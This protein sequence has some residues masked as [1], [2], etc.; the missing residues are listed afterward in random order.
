[1]GGSALSRIYFFAAVVGVFFALIGF[2]WAFQSSIEQD[3]HIAQNK[4]N[5]GELLPKGPS[6][7]IEKIAENKIRIY[8]ENLPNTSRKLEVF[9]SLLQKRGWEKW[10]T[11]ELPLNASM[12]GSLDLDL[13]DNTNSDNY[14][15]YVQTLNDAGSVAWTGPVVKAFAPPQDIF[16]SAFAPNQTTG[17]GNTTNQSEAQTSP[18]NE[19]TPSNIPQS[20]STSA[21]VTPPPPTNTT[22][23]PTDS[24]TTTPATNT[25]STP[26]TSTTQTT[27]TPTSST[28]TS[29]TYN[30]YIIY[31][32]SPDGRVVG[33]SSALMTLNFW[34]QY[35][36]RNI[37]LGWQNLP[38]Q[39]IMVK[40]FRSSQGANGPWDKLL[41]QSNIDPIGPVHIRLVDSS[42]D[43]PH[44]Y[45]AEAWVD[46][47]LL[48]TFGPVFLDALPPQ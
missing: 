26:T 23:P 42:M 48:G 34:V 22:P 40:A 7:S 5:G 10:K 29:P 45:K 16:P 41:E 6:I 37:E 25:T 32:Y 35:V 33:T 19:S 31:Y 8:W 2:Y 3:V 27:S 20:T 21:T 43:I 38:P 47:T 44:W 17:D 15:F 4:I 30:P 1:M 28:D 11:I 46:S 18:S 13:E 39:T 14:Q 9:R 36:N 12:S 24:P